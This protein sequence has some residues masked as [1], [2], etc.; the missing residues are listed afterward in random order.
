M[1]NSFTLSRSY[2]NDE[3]RSLLIELRKMSN[4]DAPAKVSKSPLMKQLFDIEKGG[5]NYYIYWSDQ[6]HMV[7]MAIECEILNRVEKNLM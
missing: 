5:D 7:K 3:L 4:A 6:Y 1:E 2:T